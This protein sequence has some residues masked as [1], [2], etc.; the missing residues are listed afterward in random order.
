[1]KIKGIQ[2]SETVDDMHTAISIAQEDLIDYDEPNLL[3]VR[4]GE[5]AYQLR[6]IA[7]VLDRI[8]KENSKPLPNHPLLK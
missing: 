5:A 4:C 6:R 2:L 8:S 1:M 7:R 3:G